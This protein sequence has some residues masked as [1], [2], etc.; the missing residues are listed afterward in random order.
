MALGVPIVSTA[1]MGTATVLRDARSARVA[2]AEVDAFA[3]AT[4]HVLRDPVLRATLGAE[5][6]RDAL[7]WGNETVMQRAMAVY[8]MTTGERCA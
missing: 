3:D 8:R 4:A 5:G 1:V 6:P 2:P 7:A